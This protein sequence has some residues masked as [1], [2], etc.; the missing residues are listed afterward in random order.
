MSDSLIPAPITLEMIQSFRAVA[1]AAYK[2]D[3]QFKAMR[4]EMIR[5]RRALRGP[6]K[7]MR[8]H[9]RRQKAAAR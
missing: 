7:G 4:S 9:I 6:S 5:L 1:D 2:S 3:V 8:R